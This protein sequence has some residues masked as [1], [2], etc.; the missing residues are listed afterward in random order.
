[1]LPLSYL[2]FL[3]LCCRE[4]EASKRPTP[5]SSVVS[6]VFP[7][8][9]LNNHVA[10]QRGVRCDAPL[11]PVLEPRGDINQT[12]GFGNRGRAQ[13]G[14]VCE[15]PYFISFKQYKEILPTKKIV[16]TV[17]KKGVY[18]GRKKGAAQHILRAT[19]ENT[20]RPKG[21]KGDGRY[22]RVRQSRWAE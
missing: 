15:W 14:Y 17:P 13:N 8:H 11:T 20:K 1:M 4:P 12:W 6:L 10:L 7:L 9:S 2:A 21:G 3:I 16:I 19:R 22:Q 5:R 18:K